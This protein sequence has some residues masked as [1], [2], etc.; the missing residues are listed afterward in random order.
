MAGQEELGALLRRARPKHRI[1]RFPG[2]A[3]LCSKVPFARILN[4]AQWLYPQ[5]FAFWPRSFAL[6]DADGRRELGFR[7]MI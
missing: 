3:A 1:A 2:M 7:V 6:P 5:A 4:Q